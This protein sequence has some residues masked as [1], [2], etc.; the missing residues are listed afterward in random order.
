MKRVMTMKF[1]I[2]KSYSVFRLLLPFRDWR[3]VTV[4]DGTL[5]TD[6]CIDAP[7]GVHDELVQARDRIARGEDYVL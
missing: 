2:E 1:R 7:E 5:N 3:L 6:W 4:E